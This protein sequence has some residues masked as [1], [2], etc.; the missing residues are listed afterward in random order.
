MDPLETKLIFQ[1]P[2]FHFHDY[3]TGGKACYRSYRP[4]YL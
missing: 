2:I 4:V 1:G 3:G